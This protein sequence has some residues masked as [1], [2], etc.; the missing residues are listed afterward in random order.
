LRKI[1]NIKYTDRDFESIKIAL[2]EYA[3]KYYPDTFK[4]L[5]EA[6]I[7]ALLVDLVAYVG[8]ILSFYLDYQANESMLE[9]AI[10]IVNILR[11]GK[12]GGYKH[13]ESATSSTLASFFVNVPIN[14]EGSGPDTKYLPI[15]QRNSV[16]SGDAG[17]NFILVED[18]DFKNENNQV[19]V[20]QRDSSG[21]PLSYAVKAFG[22]IISGLRS[23]ET[24]TVGS[25]KKFLR[26]ELSKQDISEIESVFDSEGRE[27]FE[28][29]HLSQNVVYVPVLNRGTDRDLAP[30]I[31]KPKLVSRRFKTDRER[32]KT[33][34]QFGFGSDS[35]LVDTEF[36]DPSNVLLKTI[37][38]NYISDVSF[39]PNKLLNTD[40]FGVVPSNTRLTVNYRYNTAENVNASVGS[41]NSVVSGRLVFDDVESLDST[42]LVS[43]RESLEVD[44]EEPAVGDVRLSS[45]EEIKERIYGS[46]ANQKR[47]VTSLDYASLIYNMPP[48]F[49]RVKRVGVQPGKNKKKVEIYLICEDSNGNLVSA[50]TTVKEN[51]KTWLT[52]HKMLN[53]LISIED[54]FVV[55][56]GIHF[57]A[58]GDTF[59]GSSD[60][61]RE[62]QNQL[63]RDFLLK[64]NV[65]ENF[66]ITEVYNSCK[67]IKGLLDVTNIKIKQKK[68][69]V[70]DMVYSS[71]VFDPEK[72]YSDDGLFV[73]CP[74]NVIF[75][76]K[77]PFSD[78]TGRII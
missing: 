64:L 57:E 12:T 29:D 35:T 44:N 43:I 47:A 75:E 71:V 13:S 65:G 21:N 41:I 50:N 56:L 77:Y 2:V 17:T 40:K 26:L 31:L 22:Q 68:G 49:G 30:N 45:I 39:D 59:R 23:S 36:V 38:K 58:I 54:A 16:F 1:P 42:K 24:I 74:Q 34:L 10:E 76:I 73:K 63:I 61:L 52:K 32:R 66:P 62:A 70:G 7:N 4:D 46:F 19:V 69:T 60:I 15:L 25:Y 53:D 51:V 33:F 55:N 5:N 20:A 78:I 18:V 6:G 27:Y 3:K 72:N 9:S 28:V 37:G 67:K 8:D 14:S 11:H 48:M